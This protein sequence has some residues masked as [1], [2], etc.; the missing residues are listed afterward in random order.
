M[1]D[2]VLRRD[3]NADWPRYVANDVSYLLDRIVMRLQVHGANP[4]DPGA[5]NAVHIMRPAGIRGGGRRV[6]RAVLGV[7]V[8]GRGRRR[9]GGKPASVVVATSGTWALRLLAV[10]AKAFIRPA[11]M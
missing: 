1:L 3:P 7:G 9:L 2:T 4:V 6:G 10:T 8:R 11:R 5:Q